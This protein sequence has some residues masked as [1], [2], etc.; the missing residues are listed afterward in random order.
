MLYN[1]SLLVIHFKYSTVSISVPN[2]VIVPLENVLILPLGA[3][4]YAI[5]V[6][7]ADLATF[8]L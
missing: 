5:N 3:M 2:S 6:K 1:K 8:S 7:K 4:N